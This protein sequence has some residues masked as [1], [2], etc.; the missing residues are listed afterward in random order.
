V[1]GATPDVVLAGVELLADRTGTDLVVVDVG[2]AT[3]DVYSVLTPTGEAQPAAGT[4]WRARTV[5][6]DLGV[7]WSATGVVEA[8][9][10]ERLA[11]SDGLAAADLDPADGPDDHDVELATLALTLALRRHGRARDLR[12]VRLVVGCGGVL[13]HARPEVAATV[14]GSALADHAG[15]WPLPRAAALVVDRDYVLAPAGLLAADHP[16]AA[17][18]LLANRL[19]TVPTISQ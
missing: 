6:G 10:G 2:G 5:E 9:R 3:T 7:R 19:P 4:L 15:G 11:V 14:L 12:D 17:A 13:R 16:E 1:R 18:A 8:A